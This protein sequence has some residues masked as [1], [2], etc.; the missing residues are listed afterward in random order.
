[1]RTARWMNVSCLSSLSS[2]CDKE[3]SLKCV[4][5]TALCQPILSPDASGKAHYEWKNSPSSQIHRLLFKRSCFIRISIPSQ[6][7]KWS[8]FQDIKLIVRLAMGC[9]AGRALLSQWKCNLCSANEEELP[10]HNSN[11]QRWEEQVALTASPHFAKS[12]AA[13]CNTT[14]SVLYGT[15]RL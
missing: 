12:L 4:I 8:A 2:N 6:P 5:R 10:C 3:T 1:M 15:S 14:N 9:C 13:Q 7:N 11:T